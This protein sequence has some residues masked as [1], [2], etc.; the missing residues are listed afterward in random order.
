MKTAKRLT[1]LMDS[2]SKDTRRCD[3]KTLLYI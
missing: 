3:K 1:I 2:G